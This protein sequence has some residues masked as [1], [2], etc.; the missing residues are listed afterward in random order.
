MVAISVQKL[1]PI[2]LLK[3]MITVSEFLQSLTENLSISPAAIDN[4]SVTE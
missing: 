3:A 4:R 2:T 1:E